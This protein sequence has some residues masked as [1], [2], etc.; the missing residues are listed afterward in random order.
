MNWKESRIGDFYYQVLAW[1]L[2]PV[3]K[4]KISPHGVTVFGFVTAFLV[5]LGFGLSRSL[6][7]VL[8][9][10]SAVAD[11][12]DGFLAR[13]QGQ[14]SP[15]GAF[16]DSTLD[17][18]ADF[19]YL[20]AFYLLFAQTFSPGPWLTILFFTMFLGTVL[21]S[22]TRARIEGLG[23]RCAQG[24]FG[25]VERTIFLVVWTLVLCIFPRHTSGV[26]ILGVVAYSLLTWVTVGQR[27]HAAWQVFKN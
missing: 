16:L 7:L 20:S 15:F 21:I 5:P 19:F 22:Y 25:R 4:K 24:I 2:R 14:E 1:I 10:L 27:I 6:G 8:L 17:R 11:S 18:G 13:Q 26:L 12:A 9:C 23:E 3:A